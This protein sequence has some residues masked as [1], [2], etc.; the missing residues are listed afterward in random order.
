MRVLRS[1]LHTGTARSRLRAGVKKTVDGGFAHGR[2]R[3]PRHGPSHG[4]E[5]NVTFSQICVTYACRSSTK[6]KREI[7][8]RVKTSPTTPKAPKGGSPWCARYHISY[9]RN[10]YYQPSDVTT[11]S[12]LSLSADTAVAQQACLRERR[13]QMVLSI[14]A[15]MYEGGNT[16]HVHLMCI[17]RDT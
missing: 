12:R 17:A 5:K 7:E 6:D 14:S 13:T 10:S 1:G 15:T 9:G 3:S 4:S 11:L 2:E 16:V 8:E